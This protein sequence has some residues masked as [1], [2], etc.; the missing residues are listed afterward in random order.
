MS[1]EIMEIAKTIQCNYPNIEIHQ[2]LPPISY[3][4]YQ[5]IKDYSN[6]PN[7]LMD[8][9]GVLY[10][11]LLQYYL[12]DSID[13]NIDNIKFT[14][15]IYNTINEYS[16]KIDLLF[17][18]DR[19]HNSKLN[20]YYLENVDFYLLKNDYLDKGLIPLSTN[21]MGYWILSLGITKDIKSIVDEF[22]YGEQILEKECFL[23]YY[24]QENK[25]N[26]YKMI[27]C[28]I[29]T[30]YNI[31]ILDSKK[32]WEY[33]IQLEKDYIRRDCYQNIYDIVL[34]KNNI[35]KNTIKTHYKASLFP[36]NENT[37]LNGITFLDNIA[38]NISN[39]SKSNLS[40]TN[41]KW[42]I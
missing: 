37:I 8:C 13:E 19:N 5:H 31:L 29:E 23:A 39:S 16:D 22:W 6:N 25:S 21:N 7:N 32:D 26:K 14:R 24:Y 41:G 42:F 1:Q 27:V 30:I 17:I 12:D 11:I 36:K 3:R 2:K 40:R 15:T 20:L 33:M 18:K 34:E 4:N 38:Y 10:N 9:G 28:H 35:T